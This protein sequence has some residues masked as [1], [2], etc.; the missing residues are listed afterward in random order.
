MLSKLS[1]PLVRLTLL[2]LSARWRRM[3]EPEREEFLLEWLPEP[4]FADRYDL[5][6]DFRSSG[7]KLLGDLVCDIDDENAAHVLFLPNDH[8]AVD[9]SINISH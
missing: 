7:F 5:F 9:G 1:C 4:D 8:A 6:S 3:N 2:T